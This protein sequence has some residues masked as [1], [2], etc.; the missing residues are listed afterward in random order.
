MKRSPSFQRGDLGR[1]P[2]LRTVLYTG[3]PLSPHGFEWVYRTVKEDVHF[4]G[5]SGGTDI[6]SC[7]VLGNPNLP[8]RAGEI[9]C[10]GLGVDVVAFDEKA[11]IIEDRPGE[12][13]CR[14]PLPSMPLY[15]LGDPDGGKYRQAYFD[16][17]PGLWR[18]GDFVE[19]KSNGGII[20]HGR[21]DATLNPGGVRIGSS[22]L[23][24]AL[25]SVPELKEALAVGWRPPA[26][27]DEVIV[28]FVVLQENRKWELE[29]GEKIRKAIRYN[30]SPK[31]VPSVILPISAIPVTR[32][33]KPV[34]LS[35]KAILNGES[36]KDRTALAN[37][38]ILSEFEE[39]REEVLRQWIKRHP[40]QR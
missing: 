36:L 15:F 4:A 1:F 26:T 10:R 11:N 16:T 33:G 40:M 13:V 28:L 25:D 3:S 12:L 20:L 30:C 2:K 18:H 14:Q 19:F 31:H 35:V 5:I 34:E 39:A 22:E 29:I 38:E 24:S 6:V 17:Y 21:S 7:F 32:S 37:P 8:V 27:S 23:Y 9:Q